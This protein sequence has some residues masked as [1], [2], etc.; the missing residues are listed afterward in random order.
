MSEKQITF[1]QAVLDFD[2][3]TNWHLTILRGEQQPLDGGT[4][5]SVVR[6]MYAHVNYRKAHGKPYTAELRHTD[7]TGQTYV[8]VLGEGKW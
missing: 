7:P 6:A 5:P 2:R 4:H 3:D 1:S 8:L